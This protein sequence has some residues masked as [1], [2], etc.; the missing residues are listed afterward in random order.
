MLFERQTNKCWVERL[1]WILINQDH[2]GSFVQAG[3]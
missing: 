3:R 2:D 1:Y